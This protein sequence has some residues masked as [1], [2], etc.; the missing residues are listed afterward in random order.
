M[1]LKKTWHNYTAEF[2]MKYDKSSSLLCK[3]SS[4]LLTHLHVIYTVAS[5]QVN[6]LRL[7]INGHDCKTDI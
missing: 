2:P 6:A 7:L 4:Q 1:V 5:I 3:L